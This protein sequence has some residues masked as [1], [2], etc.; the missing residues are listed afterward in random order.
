MIA[1][2]L[3]KCSTVGETSLVLGALD[4]V[5]LGVGV[6]STS[7]SEVLDGFSVLVSSQEERV[8]A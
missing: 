1:C 2:P 8:S 5:W 3:L 4:T 7:S 6:G